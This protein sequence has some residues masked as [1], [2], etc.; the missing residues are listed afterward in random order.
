MTR[1]T[2]GRI[3]VILAATS[4]FF[5]LTILPAMARLPECVLCPPSLMP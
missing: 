1:R 5:A 2:K 4:T 3:A